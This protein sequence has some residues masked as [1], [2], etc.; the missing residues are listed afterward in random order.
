MVLNAGS[1]RPSFQPLASSDDEL[2]W[3]KAEGK[4]GMETPKHWRRT[5]F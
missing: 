3:Q 5:L 2:V 1:L 4:G